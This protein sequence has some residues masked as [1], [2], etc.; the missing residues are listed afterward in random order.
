M[1]A[2]NNKTQ[3]PYCQRWITLARG[4]FKH[5]VRICRHDDVTSRHDDVTSTNKRPS[6][7]PLLSRHIV[8]QTEDI[9][10]DCDYVGDDEDNEDINNEITEFST[11]DGH[12]LDN[13]STYNKSPKSSSLVTKFQVGLSNIVNKHKASVCLCVRVSVRVRPKI[14]HLNF[15]LCVCVMPKIVD[16]KSSYS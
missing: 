11:N 4:G 1:E 10:Y 12:K 3:C 9:E 5:H 2:T 6:T 7:N 16:N 14:V 15:C 8:G 13:T